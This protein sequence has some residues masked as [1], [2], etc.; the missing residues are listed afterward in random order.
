MIKKIII[1][2]PYGYHGGTLVLEAL[3]KYLR[4]EGV[5]ARIFYIFNSYPDHSKDFPLWRNL[6][7]GIFNEYFFRLCHVVTLDRIIRRFRERYAFY[8]SVVPGI[9][10]Q[11]FPF[12]SKK[13]TI[14]LYPDSV[15]GNILN[16]VNVVRW[17]LYY[18]RFPGDRSAYNDDDLIIC[19]RK[20]FNDWR[21]TA[22]CLQVKINFFD[23]Q[24]YH[25]YNFGHREGKCYVIRKGGNRNDLPSF[26]D[27]PVVDDLDET[28]KVR[29]FN[30][31][32]YC[33][34]Y[35][36]Q[37]FYTYIAAVCGCIPVVVMESQKSKSDYLSE[38]ELLNIVGVAYGDSPEEIEYAI[39]TR[40]QLLKNL[41]YD[42]RNREETCK[43]LKYT[44]NR[45][46]PIK[47]FYLCMS[48][49]CGVNFC[50]HTCL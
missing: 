20:I 7:W 5:D 47:R 1:V 39:N 46:G 8:S 6:F 4:L 9:K 21:S 48:F 37:T 41:D 3:G 18:N 19:F 38:E 30:K 16:G 32:K 12:F 29:I 34:F 26:F 45:F 43:F 11:F 23:R 35:D 49:L 50:Y 40:E 27:G 10:R 33:Y 2:R 22:N 24:K 13:T 25:Q 36:T 31:S 14:V 17:F 28:E 15:Y 44:E 42:E